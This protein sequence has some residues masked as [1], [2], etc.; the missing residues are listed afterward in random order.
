MQVKSIAECLFLSD[1]LRQVLQYVAKEDIKTQH[2]NGGML[3]SGK[4]MTNYQ[5]QL[6]FK[7]QTKYWLVSLDHP[8]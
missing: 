5:S 2:E 6:S 8:Q 1:R 7:F 4:I 3:W